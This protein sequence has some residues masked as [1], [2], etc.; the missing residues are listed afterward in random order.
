MRFF[1]LLLLFSLN[2]SLH[3]QNMGIKLAS[4]TL[5]NTT[6]DVNGS[7]AFREGTALNLTL[8]VNND[9]ALGAFSFFRITGATTGFSITGFAN[10]TDGRVLTI[11]NATGQLLTLTHQT[12]STS[13]SANQINTGGTNLTLGNN[14]VATL[15]YMSHF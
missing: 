1:T 14:G 5:P 7:T 8:A 3:A 11:V 6:L 10:G 4:G 2:I 12:T 15:V 13:S 9:V